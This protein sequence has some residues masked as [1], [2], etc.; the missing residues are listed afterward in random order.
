MYICM[1]MHGIKMY[2]TL[3]FLPIKSLSY[4]ETVCLVLLKKTE[5]G[6]LNIFRE[7]NIFQHQ[8]TFY[9]PDRD[10][11]TQEYTLHDNSLHKSIKR[12]AFSRNR[13]YYNRRPGIFFAVHP[14]YNS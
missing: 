7:R 3:F 6:Y 4:H 9:P 2:H 14:S 10:K 1:Y 13:F 8:R 12:A 5:V 11:Q